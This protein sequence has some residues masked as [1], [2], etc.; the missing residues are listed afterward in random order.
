MASMWV[1]TCKCTRASTCAP[2]GCILLGVLVFCLRAEGILKKTSNEEPIN[3]S[4]KLT[5]LIAKKRNILNALKR[6]S[7]KIE[8][9]RGIKDKDKKDKLQVLELFR[10]ELEATDRSLLTVIGDFERTLNSGFHSIDDIKESC[11]KRLEDMR[12]V[13]LQVE[14]DF[15]AILA[16]QKDIQLHHPSSNQGN[17]IMIEILHTLAHAADELEEEL[18]DDVFDAALSK[19][20]VEVET[21]VKLSH[22][23]SH[24]HL[25]VSDHIGRGAP[26]LIDPQ[27]NQYS[28]SRPQD[29]TIPHEDHNLLYDLLLL[30]LSC[31]VFGAVFSLVRAPAVFGYIFT[32][33]LF[34]PSG[35]NWV[36]VCVCVC[37]CVVC[38]CVVC[39][40]YVCVCV[41]VC[42][43]VGVYTVKLIVP[44]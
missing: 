31:F 36:K 42:V 18:K 2:V 30:H 6:S 23:H 27:S 41:C 33:V 39:V 11:F 17:S 8:S 38:V 44:W 29:T 9:D 28:L 25:R 35:C 15:N 26:V 34:G 32:G 22:F 12:N 14:E 5:L 37:V 43:C 24:T 1:G 16:L 40:V 10:R 13:S 7:H 4:S 20:N 3:P 21:V 19:G